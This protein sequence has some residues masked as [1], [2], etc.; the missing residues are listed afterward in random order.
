MHF[1]DQFSTTLYARA[2]L[3]VVVVVVVVIS[4]QFKQFNLE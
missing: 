4:T 3:A 1:I 2:R